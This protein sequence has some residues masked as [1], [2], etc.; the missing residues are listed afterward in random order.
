MLY[1]CIPAYNESETVGLLL[2]RIRRVFQDYS[3]EYEIIV[4]D[5]ASTD[6]TRE[7]L[8]P[9][10][11]VIPL[12]VIGGKERVG[13]GRALEALCREVTRKTRYPRRDAMIVM[14]ADF[15]DQPEQ[16]PELVKRFEGGTDIVTTAQTSA[17]APVQVK[18]LK[19][20]SDWIRKIVMPRNAPA[21][22]FT[23]FRCYR[24]TVLKDLIKSAGDAPFI[25]SDG[26]AANAELL[27]RTAPLA[28]RIETLA[29][30]PRYD[31][32]VRGTRLQPFAGALG[33]Y[34]VGRNARRLLATGT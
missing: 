8:E 4:Y 22:A 9:Y 1:I 23:T 34:R 3:R 11:E 16:I 20:L 32:R 13:Y 2:W 14:Q 6:A 25:T 31:L 26:W 33:I 27:F 5:D 7:T 18:R 15:T 17:G 21:D 28:R 29:Q 24:I 19:H 30:E 12:S 10:K